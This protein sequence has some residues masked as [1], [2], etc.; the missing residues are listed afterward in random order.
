MVSGFSRMQEC[1]VL[2]G[3]RVKGFGLRGLRVSGLRAGLGCR[4]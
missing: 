2:N 4:A 1:G 3:F